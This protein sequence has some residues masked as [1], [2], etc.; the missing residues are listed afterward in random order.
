MLLVML[1]FVVN[2]MGYHRPGFVTGVFAAGYALSRIFCEFFREPDPQLG[3]I[4]GDFATMGML[5][6]LPMLAIGL[7]LIL[8]AKSAPIV[9]S[10]QR[11]AS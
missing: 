5:L 9:G 7:W 6:S 11:H 1:A 3:F 4:L 10:I 8:R 2:R